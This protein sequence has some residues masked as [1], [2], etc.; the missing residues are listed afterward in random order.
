MGKYEKWTS[1]ILATIELASRS[2][3]LLCSS[4]QTLLVAV[5]ILLSCSDVLTSLRVECMNWGKSIEIRFEFQTT[6]N[7]G[8]NLQ[9]CHFTCFLASRLTQNQ[10][11]YYL[12]VQKKLSWLAVWKWPC[13]HTLKLSKI[14]ANTNHGLTPASINNRVPFLC[15]H[16]S[17]SGSLTFKVNFKCLIYPAVKSSDSRRAL[18]KIELNSQA[19]VRVKR[20]HLGVPA[21]VVDS[22][23]LCHPQ[24][25][26]LP[27]NTR[28]ETVRSVWAETCC[29][30]TM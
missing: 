4:R 26:T 22:V 7:L 15:I 27:Q 8:F 21:V 29:I 20:G 3:E 30:Y 17:P 2:A 6:S 14:E 28:K 11:G 10:C 18:A 5:W 1:F 13:S 19:C 9:K 16:P 23:S 12:D 24:H 25:W